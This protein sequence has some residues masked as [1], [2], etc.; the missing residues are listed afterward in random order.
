MPQ[1]CSKLSYVNFEQ[2]GPYREIPAIRPQRP[3]CL[4]VRG[5]VGSGGC[6]SFLTAREPP[7]SPSPLAE[8]LGVHDSSGMQRILLSAYWTAETLE[9]DPGVCPHKSAFRSHVASA[10]A[11][12]RLHYYS[13]GFIQYFLLGSHCLPTSG[14]PPHPI[15]FKA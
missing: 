6:W 7:G 11:L 1:P 2:V 10:S 15:P 12:L 3:G 4:G 8:P 14:S 9:S 5:R 13:N